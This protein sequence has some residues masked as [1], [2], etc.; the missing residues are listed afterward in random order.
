MVDTSYVSSVRYCCVCVESPR[1][2]EEKTGKRR[3]RRPEA[4]QCRIW[5]SHSSAG[6]KGISKPRGCECESASGVKPVLKK[7][8]GA[9]DRAN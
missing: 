9:Y 7:R 1:L 8:E 4:G 6:T 5:G 2:E 3:T